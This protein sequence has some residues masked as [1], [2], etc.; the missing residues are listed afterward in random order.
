MKDLDLKKMYRNMRIREKANRIVEIANNILLPFQYIFKDLFLLFNSYNQLLGI[1]AQAIRILGQKLNW[2]I[3]IGFILEG[4]STA[5]ESV[6]S[7]NKN[8][9]TYLIAQSG[10]LI[11]GGIAISIIAVTSPQVYVPILCA[12]W[13]TSTVM[14]LYRTIVDS[15]KES[16]EREYKKEILQNVKKQIQE[17]YPKTLRLKMG[18]NKDFLDQ[19][20]L[21]FNAQQKIKQYTKIHASELQGELIEKAYQLQEKQ[22]YITQNDIVNIIDGITN[23]DELNPSTRKW[24]KNNENS[25]LSLCYMVSA[26]LCV[27]T[28]FFFLGITNIEQNAI[29][30]HLGFTL[31]MVLKRAK[32]YLGDR[33]FFKSKVYKNLSSEEVEKMEKKNFRDGILKR[34]L[35]KLEASVTRILH[36]KTINREKLTKLLS[37]YTAILKKID[38]N[39]PEIISKFECLE[40]EIMKTTDENQETLFI[41]AKTLKQGIIS[42]KIYLKSDHSCVLEKAIFNV[43]L[44]YIPKE[45]ILHQNKQSPG[46]QQHKKPKKLGR[47]STLREIAD[48]CSEL[49]KNP[50]KTQK[51]RMHEE[52]LKRTHLEHLKDKPNSRQ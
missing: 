7:T 29:L 36:Q 17:Q 50:G 22:G 51:E 5:L 12:I 18:E 23:G 42:R 44:V 35:T 46:L 28:M 15:M 25:I 19:L 52:L 14:S 13:G 4:I 32:D 24:I 6:K 27:F 30:A 10:F 33:V 47:Y 45:E 43:N 8:K 37:T 1:S 49:S 40:S 16:K 34:E 39:K 11:V 2:L 21:I 41:L 48:R 38:P 20:T 3:G 9:A 31:G 26:C